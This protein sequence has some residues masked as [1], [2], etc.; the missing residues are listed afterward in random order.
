MNA[1]D[2]FFCS[3]LRSC[4]ASLRTYK[5]L[6]FIGYRLQGTSGDQLLLLLLLHAAEQVRGI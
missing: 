5:Y 1:Y 6:N 2:R 4:S 3:A